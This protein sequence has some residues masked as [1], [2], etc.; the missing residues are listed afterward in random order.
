MPDFPENCIRGIREKKYIN[1]DGVTVFAALFTPYEKTA[2]NR[3]DGCMETSINWEDNEEVMSFTL[4][5]RV[6]GDTNLAFPNGAVRIPIEKMDAINTFDA[7]RDSIFYERAR[8][9]GN[10]YHG[11]IVFRKHL[12]KNQITFIANMLAAASSKV[13]T[14][15]G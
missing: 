11:N 9:S 3:E 15:N 1:P 12:S 5:Y 6:N 8:I 14:K 2:G 13:Y 4:N 7:T 10:E